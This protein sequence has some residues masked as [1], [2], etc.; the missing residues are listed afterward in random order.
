MSLSVPASFSPLLQGAQVSHCVN[1]PELIFPFFSPL[2][3]GYF[4]HEA[5]KDG[6]ST[7]LLMNSPMPFHGLCLQGKCPGHS[8]H[9]MCS[10]GRC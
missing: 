2:A 6:A 3:L 5:V 4:Q 1:K 8:V 7:D 10:S 9:I